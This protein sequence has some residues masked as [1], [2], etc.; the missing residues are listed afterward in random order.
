MPIPVKLLKKDLESIL[1]KSFGTPTID[2]W[3]VI[4]SDPP[5]VTKA[6]W[7]ADEV[8]YQGEK[9]TYY[10]EAQDQLEAFTKALKLQEEKHGRIDAG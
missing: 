5:S 3:G 4:L 10:V 9:E 7:W 2:G 6:Q 1:N 8:M